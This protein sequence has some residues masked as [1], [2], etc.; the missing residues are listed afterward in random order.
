MKSDAT[1]GPD[2]RWLTETGGERG[3]AYAERFAALEASGT[4]VHGEADLVASLA[5]VGARVLDAGC[6]TGRVAIELARRGYDVTGVDIDRS[7]LGVA[8]ESAPSLLWVEADLAALQLDE[9]PYDVVVAAGNVMIFL[10]RGTEADVV[11]RLADHLAPGGLLVAGF[12][13]EADRLSLA[14]YDRYCAAVGLRL[15]DRWSTWDRKPWQD[16]DDYAVSV[17]GRPRDISLLPQD[18]TILV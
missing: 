12:T 18:S 14:D 17:Q 10:A 13:V 15:L 7:M 2:N 5:P 8:R 11:R 1:G 4:Y 16:G 9:P 3:R 6:G